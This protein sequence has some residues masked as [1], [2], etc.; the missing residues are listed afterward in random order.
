M[1]G[2]LLL[3]ATVGLLSCSSASAK[4]F[5]ITGF[6]GDYEAAYAVPPASIT[7]LGQGIKR[8]D[9][10]SVDMDN[11]EMEEGVFVTTGTLDVTVIEVNCQSAPRQFKEDSEY[12]QFFR[13]DKPIDK[14]SLNP[15]KTWTPIPAG[16]SIESDADFICLWPKTSTEAAAIKLPAADEWAFVD[17]VVDTVSRIREK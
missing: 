11:I 10:I 16:S 8:A 6:D 2:R 3:I 14:T 7:D 1:N 5:Y 12:V 4:D 17:S 15:Y 9:M 13:K